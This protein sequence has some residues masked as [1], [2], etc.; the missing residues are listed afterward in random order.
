MAMQITYQE[1]ISVLLKLLDHT[2][3]MVDSG[4]QLPRWVYPAPVEIDTGQVTPGASIDDAIRVEH[5]YDFED[6]VITEDLCL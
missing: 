2:L 4:M 3:H 1:H 6:K 5:G